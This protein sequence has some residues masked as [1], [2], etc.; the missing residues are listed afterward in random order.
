[1]KRSLA[2]SLDGKS[3]NIGSHLKREAAGTVH[4]RLQEHETLGDVHIELTDGARGRHKR[5]FILADD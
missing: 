3:V 2:Y 5:S 4:V 1:M